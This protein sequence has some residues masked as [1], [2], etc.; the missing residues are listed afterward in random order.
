MCHF[1]V[2][3]EEPSK[4]DASAPV[5]FDREYAMSQERH[6]SNVAARSMGLSICRSIIEAHDG[7][8]EADNSPLW[9]E[10]ASVLPCPR[11]G[12]WQADS[13]YDPQPFNVIDPLVF[14]RQG[15]NNREFVPPI[16]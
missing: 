1:K 16:R 13:P 10:P 9:E 8:I 4:S 6:P 15:P 11:I 7:H 2:N 12:L 14:G 5:V 3:F